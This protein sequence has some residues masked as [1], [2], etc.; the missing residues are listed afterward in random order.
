MRQY[1]GWINTIHKTQDISGCSLFF[2]SGEV[3]EKTQLWRSLNGFLRVAFG[4]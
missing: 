4:I 1:M 2:Y 3:A